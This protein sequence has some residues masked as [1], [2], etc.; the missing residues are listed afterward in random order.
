MRSC[1]HF[2]DCTG[3]Y[4]LQ[5][6]KNDVSL[7]K[8]GITNNHNTF[9]SYHRPQSSEMWGPT[10]HKV[11]NSPTHQFRNSPT[12]KLTDSE[13]PL[14]I[15]H[16]QSAITKHLKSFKVIM[17]HPSSI[18]NSLNPKPPNQSCILKDVY[19][20]IIVFMT[21]CQNS[22]GGWRDRGKTDCGNGWVFVLVLAG[23]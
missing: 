8:L 21:S 2:G 23:G 13:N 1:P 6:W 9:L 17:N 22:G 11:T 16:Q 3:V 4:A 12:H 15:I 5:S 19:I 7:P 18:M 20:Q 10:T 14:S